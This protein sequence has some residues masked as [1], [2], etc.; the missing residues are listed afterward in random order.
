VLFGDAVWR[1]GLHG[2]RQRNAEVHSRRG[3]RRMQIAVP[4]QRPNIHAAIDLETGKTRM[5]EVA[6]VNRSA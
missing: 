1:F 3:V 6:T 5:V 2:W 4:Q